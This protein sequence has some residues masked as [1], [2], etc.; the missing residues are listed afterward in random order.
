[1]VEGDNSMLIINVFLFVSALVVFSISV[2]FTMECIAALF[3]KT[4]YGSIS[5]WPNTKVAVLVPA[6]NEEVVIASTL[7][8]LTSVLKKQD[9]LVVVADNCSDDT[10][11][12]ARTMG[13][14]VIERNDS[15]NRGKGYAL[16]YGLEFIN[17]EPPDVLIVVDADC[18]VH[19]DAIEQLTERVVTTGQPVQAT[20]L[21]AA[22]SDSKSASYFLSQFSNIVRNLVRPLGLDRLG[23]TCPL[24]GTGMAFP[25]SAICSV[26]LANGHLL[27]D[28]K[29]GM[30]LTILGH[31]PIFCPQAKV[32]SYLPESNQAAKSQKTRWVHGHFQVMQTYIPILLKEAVKQKRFDLLT[33]ALDLCIPPLS[34]LVVVWF[35]FGVTSL[36]SAALLGASWIPAITVGIAGFCMFAALLTTWGKFA[37][38]VLPFHKLLTV[39]FYIFW[40][41]T[42]Y[43]QF[44]VKPQE[45]WV[46]TE[47]KK[48]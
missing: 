46:R 26:N 7:E 43:F 18:T 42:V 40:K 22:S 36:L 24:L 45:T 5:N 15:R 12:I 39:P 17:S 13:A 1:M 10:A 25:W 8:G 35:A 33:S 4:F 19:K 11:K 48:V 21:M 20:Y 37:R 34:L 3:P 47:R 29:L 6:H 9:R 28:L 41:I 16:D 23:I 44:L 38:Q 2:F 14:T 27:E 32:T 30:D 31:K